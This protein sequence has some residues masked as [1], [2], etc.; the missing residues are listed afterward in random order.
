MTDPI[1]DKIVAKLYGTKDYDAHRL[2]LPPREGDTFR[3][4]FQ[5][6]LK[7]R[8][9]KRLV[10]VNYFDDETAAKAYAKDMR[11]GDYTVKVTNLHPPKGTGP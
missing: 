8:Y 11:G 10:A 4:P 1:V 9:S 7:N 5:V 6:T 2:T 3:W